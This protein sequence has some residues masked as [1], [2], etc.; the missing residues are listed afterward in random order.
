MK[1]ILFLTP[2][3]PYPP[4]SGGVIKSFKLVSYLAVHYQ[5]GLMCFLKNDD[6][7]HE[8]EFVSSINLADYY[9]ESI[10][11]PRSIKNLLKSYLHRVPL[12]V[13]RNFSLSFKQKVAESINNYDIVFVDHFL[14][15]QFIPSNFRGRIVLHQH[16]AEYVMWERMAKNEKSWIKS[17]IIVIESN[18]LKKFEEKYA[19]GRIRF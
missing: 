16:N 15:F 3:L 8:K 14:M 7:I 18:R 6:S 2:Q 1:K 4:I 19:N 9:S 10:D 12:S 13:Y 17:L 11:K 5:L